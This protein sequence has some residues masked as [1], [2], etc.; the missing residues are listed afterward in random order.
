MVR[1]NL[2]AEEDAVVD[3]FVARYRPTVTAMLH[4]FDRLVFRGTLLPLVMERGPVGCGID[5]ADLSEH[6]GPTD[7]QV[8]VSDVHRSAHPVTMPVPADG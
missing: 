5:S 7:Y 6:G 4:G 3:T 1:A 2:R 8:T